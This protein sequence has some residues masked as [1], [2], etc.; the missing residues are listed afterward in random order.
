MICA[1]NCASAL[2]ISELTN[3][4]YELQGGGLVSELRGNIQAS[5]DRVQKK[6]V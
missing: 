2:P 1:K 6:C 5:G 3:R 4:F